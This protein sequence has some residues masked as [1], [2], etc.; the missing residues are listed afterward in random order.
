MLTWKFDI[1]VEA[2]DP[3]L[4]SKEKTQ[5]SI[6]LCRKILIVFHSMY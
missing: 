5:S 6:P 1:K 2:Q 3:G 4:K